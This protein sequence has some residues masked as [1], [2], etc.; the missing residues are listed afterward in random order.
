MSECLDNYRKNLKI[1]T[2]QSGM[3]VSEIARK[4]GIDVS[5]LYKQLSGKAKPKYRSAIA[6]ANVFG[7]SLD[8]LLGLSDEYEKREYTPAPPFCDRFNAALKGKGLSRYRFRIDYNIR[9]NCADD[10]ANGV[11]EPTI[12]NLVKLAGIFGMTADELVGRKIKN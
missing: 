4:T 11:H 12:D 6:V 1:L 9:E 2:E 5:V 8:Y 3:S 7:C 10:W